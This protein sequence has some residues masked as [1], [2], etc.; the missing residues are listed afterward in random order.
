MLVAMEEF[1]PSAHDNI[2]TG[3]MTVFEEPGTKPVSPKHKHARKQPATTPRARVSASV[4]KEV[5]RNKV[6]TSTSVLTARPEV[7][8]LDQKE[9]ATPSLVSTCAV[10]GTTLPPGVATHPVVVFPVPVPVQAAG[11]DVTV[12][13]DTEAAT[14]DTPGSTQ[15]Q[16]IC[17]FLCRCLEKVMHPV[18]SGSSLRT[19]LSR[20]DVNAYVSCSVVAVARHSIALVCTWRATDI[21]DVC[22]KGH[23]MAN[24]VGR[25]NDGFRH[26]Q[27]HLFGQKWKVDVGEAVYRDFLAFDDGT[28]LWEDLQ[29]HVLRDGMCVLYLHRAVILIIQHGD[30]FVVVDCGERNTLGLVSDIGRSAVVFNTC[31]N[32]LMIHILNLKESL[33][34]EWFGVSS[35]S[36]EQCV[37]EGEGCSAPV[38]MA[39]KAPTQYLNSV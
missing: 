25:G 19:A 8:V 10:S 35:I 12:V 39:P 29:Q 17:P 14:R 27:L 13:H 28:E 36:V 32:D 5:A 37:A 34:A 2:S 4:R 6:E 33:G 1:A 15:R 11:P 18:V 20:F 9:E 21:D 26:Q 24:R 31:L 30:F 38:L 22:D 23:K 16:H 3:N 7:W